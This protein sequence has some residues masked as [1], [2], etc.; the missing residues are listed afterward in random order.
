MSN[1]T[2][3]NITL[4]CIVIN[5]QHAVLLQP[6][7]LRVPRIGTCTMIF[8]LLRIAVPILRDEEPL[9]VKLY[10]PLTSILSSHLSELTKAE[11]DLE[12]PII[13]SW[14]TTQW[15]HSQD[16]SR[17]HIIICVHPQS[18]FFLIY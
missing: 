4:H 18:M 8:P 5:G 16:T 14:L 15:I 12:D 6:F 17:I 1:T 3:V 2:P 11:V 13:P 9:V 7:D 10:R